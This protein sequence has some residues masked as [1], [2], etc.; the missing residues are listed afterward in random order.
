ME[1][2]IL[3]DD[4]VKGEKQI[5]I[6]KREGLISEITD[7]SILQG[8][9]FRWHYGVPKGINDKVVGP[10]RIYVS[11]Y[12]L[13]GKIDENLF[14]EREFNFSRGTG[15]RPMFNLSEIKDHVPLNTFNEDNIFEIEYGE[16]PQSLECDKYIILERN[17]RKKILKKT[18]KK[19]TI[20]LKDNTCPK[21]FEEFEY[22]G[23]K[24]IRIDTRYL[25]SNDII[26]NDY[27]RLKRRK[28]S[29]A[30]WIKVEPIKWFVDPKEDLVLSKK[31]LFTD[32][33]WINITDY[34][35]EYFSKEIIPIK[36]DF[37][38]LENNNRR[39][40]NYN[41]EIQ[42]L[43]D[44]I[45][46][47]LKC[48][49]KEEEVKNIVNNLISEHNCKLNNLKDEQ[50]LSLY[51]EDTLKEMLITKLNILIDKLKNYCESNQE[52]YK[53]LSVIEQII[54]IING[55]KIEE[56]DNELIKDFNILFSFCIPFLKE[57]DNNKITND[58]LNKIIFEKNKIINYL[59]YSESFNDSISLKQYEKPS[60]SNYQEFE[61]ELRSNI[62]PILKQLDNK[63]SKRNIELE[64]IEAFDKIRKNL[65]KESKT[66]ILFVYL[67]EINKLKKEAD[68]L[69]FNF[70]DRKYFERLVE[71]LNINIDY[72]KDIIQILN[73]LSLIIVSLHKLIFQMQEEIKNINKRKDSYVMVKI[74]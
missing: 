56:A 14:V 18:H 37:I 68:I 34:M 64:V 10:W 35:E 67:N 9:E 60:Y 5:R 8:A 22:E 62:Q 21:Q 46:E 73:D 28:T 36:N 49:Q 23:N 41:S 47:Y 72:S 12:K 19:Y 59:K 52:Y 50:I 30:F 25:D 2:K 71:I 4:Q 11:N 40:N 66:K 26:N 69:L 7:L 32:Y 6:L 54:N 51:N 63:V 65:Y 29:F 39:L 42:N 24:Y 17:Y 3:T 53:I 20:Y 13:D 27:I 31:I 16:W 43:L 58:L 57:E 45:N 15:V 70:N 33:K 1:F 48:I 38:L 55:T 61:L 74:K 44:K